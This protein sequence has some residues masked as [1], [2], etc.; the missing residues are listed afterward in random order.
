MG[1]DVDKARRDKATIYIDD[2]PALEG[3]GRRDGG[4]AAVA[5]PQVAPKPGIAASVHDPAVG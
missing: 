5:Y 2:L 3:R 4:H 1:V